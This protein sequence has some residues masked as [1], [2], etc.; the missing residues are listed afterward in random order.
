MLAGVATSRSAKHKYMSMARLAVEPSLEL[1][2][3]FS[4]CN[5]GFD[6]LK[7]IVFHYDDE[8]NR[9]LYCEILDLKQPEKQWRRNQKSSSE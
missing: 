1:S 7:W 6:E 8:K 4:I 2:C 5:M 9:T 3:M